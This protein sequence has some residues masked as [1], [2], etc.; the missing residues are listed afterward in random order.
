[1]PAA[2]GVAARAMA[3]ITLAGAVAQQT[4]ECL[5]AMVLLQIINPGTPVVFGAF[6]TNVDMRSGAPAFGTPEY[7]RAMQMSG[8]MARFYRLPWRGSNANAANFPDAQAAWESVFSLWGVITGGCNMVYH[9]AG[10]LEGGLQASFEKFI[11]DCE[12]LQN[13]FH[14]L[15]PIGVTEEDLAVDVIKEVGPQ[16]HFFGT[17]HTQARYETQF[18]KP[19]LSDWRNHGGWV[20]A[21]EPKA[22]DHANRLW[23]QA[24]SEYEEPPMDPAIREEIDAYVARRIAEGGVPTDF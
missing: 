13:I 22:H 5:A 9:G 10:W 7:M 12:I 14:Y 19:F 8:Q 15:E 18:Y 4:A 20:E 6:T 3:P 23:K 24:L 17:A 1:M 2:G 16:G 11:I 21:G